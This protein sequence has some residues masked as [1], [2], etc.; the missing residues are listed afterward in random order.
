ME[1]I[2]VIDRKNAKVSEWDRVYCEIVKKI[3][4]EGVRVEN[5]TGVDTLTTGAITFTLHDI[6][7]NFPILETKKVAIKNALSE[8]QWIH[9]EQ[10]NDV[11]WL[12]ERENPIWDDWMIDED[13]IYRKYFPSGTPFEEKKVIVVDVDGKPLTDKYGKDLMTE[14]TTKAKEKGRTIKEAIY[15]GEEWAHTIGKAYGYNNNQTKDPQDVLYKIKNKPDDRRMIIDLRIKENLK[16]GT[17]E[18]CVWCTEW[19]VLGNKL[20]LFVH[21]RSGDIPVGV[22]FNV[23]QYAA[24]LKMFAKVNNLEAGDLHYSINDAHIYVDQVEPIKKQL[25]NYDLMNYYEIF[26]RDNSD[27]EIL[28]RYYS[29]VTQ[30]EKLRTFLEANPDRKEIEESHKDVLKHFQIMNLMLTKKNPEFEV[31]DLDNFFDINTDINNNPE[32]LKENP[33]GNKDLVLK[34]YSSMPFIKIPVA[35]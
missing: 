7:H 9:Q 6:E 13:G 27:D 28:K 25:Y 34:N 10:T 19:R 8:I 30:E 22:P 17:L 16:Y 12:Q 18:P 11:R 3:L 2:K 32:Y 24:L 26:I 23:T 33:T 1:S 14:A 21:Q 4:N 29:F 35:Q 20:H 15:F 5:R 31:A